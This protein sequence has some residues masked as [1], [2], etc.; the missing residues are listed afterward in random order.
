MKKVAGPSLGFL[1]SDARRDSSHPLYLPRAASAEEEGEDEQGPFGQGGDGFRGWRVEEGRGHVVN[2]KGSR[3]IKRTIGPSD[4]DAK[5]R[6]IYVSRRQRR[7][8]RPR[9]APLSA[10][11]CC[12]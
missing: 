8:G 12:T 11:W 6:T 3:K 10:G 4:G 2:V 5:L 1:A 9:P 7:R